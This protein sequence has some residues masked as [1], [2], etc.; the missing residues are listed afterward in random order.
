MIGGLMNRLFRGARRLWARA[1]WLAALG[2][3]YADRIMEAPLTDRIH[4][5]QGRSTG[6]WFV[7]DPAIPLRVYLKRHRRL[8]L[9]TRVLATLW[10]S[11]NWSPGWTEHAHLLWAQRQGIPVPAPVA[12]GEFIGPGFRLESFLAIEELVGMIPL[13]EAIPLAEQE[14]DAAAFRRWK[15]SCILE[16]ASLTRLLHGQHRYHRDLYLCHFFVLPAKATSV[17]RP[18]DMFLIDLHRL[19][20]H[21]WT[22]WYWRIKDLAQLLYSSDVPG[23]SERD[24]LRFFR[25]YLNGPVNRRLL[26]AVRLKTGRYQRHNQRQTPPT[27]RTQRQTASVP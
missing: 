7:G 17:I 16:A 19:G 27:L 10:P 9:L 23:I 3:D 15:R 21:P 1:D 11:A 14:L 4:A 26:S 25:H 24:R 20:H 6:R 8:S 12:V 13:N 18:G 22:G 2:D 5:K